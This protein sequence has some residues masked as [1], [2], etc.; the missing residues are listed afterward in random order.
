MMSEQMGKLNREIETEKNKN[1]RSE[2]S[3][4]ENL[5]DGLNSGLDIAVKKISELYTS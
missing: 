3:E 5:T 1:S 4:M 2:K